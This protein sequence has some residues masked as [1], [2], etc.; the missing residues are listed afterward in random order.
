MDG[1]HILVNG[2]PVP[3]PAS[4]LLVE[5]PPHPDGDAAWYGPI[6]VRFQGKERRVNI[7]GVDGPAVKIVYE[8]SP[9]GDYALCLL[10]GKDDGTVGV[11]TP[12]DCVVGK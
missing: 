7:R 11:N 12:F 1:P 4:G 10:S 9:G 6:E 2:V 3:F 8:Q 5:I